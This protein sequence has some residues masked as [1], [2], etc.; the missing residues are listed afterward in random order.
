MLV[1]SFFCFLLQESFNK[2]HFLIFAG[3]RLEGFVAIEE[4]PLTTKEI[5]PKG[6]HMTTSFDPNME[7]SIPAGSLS[8]AA[9]VKMMVHMI[10]HLLSYMDRIYCDMLRTMKIY[11]NISVQMKASDWLSLNTVLKLANG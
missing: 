9:L 2:G 5:G 10:F 8:K 3:C 1:F 7:A 4:R 6:G 11:C